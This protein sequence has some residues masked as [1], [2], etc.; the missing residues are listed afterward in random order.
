VS[1]NKVL[2]SVDEALDR[3]DAFAKILYR[4]LF[5]WILS[6]VSLFSMEHA[7]QRIDESV[8][9]LLD[10]FGFEVGLT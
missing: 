1:G 4:E 10:M 6:R 9:T 7:K 2:L 3:R 8:I 5:N